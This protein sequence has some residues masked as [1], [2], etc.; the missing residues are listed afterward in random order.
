MTNQPSK[1]GASVPPAPP[2]SQAADASAPLVAAVR[3]HRKA[4]E[5]EDATL[6]EMAALL[7]ELTRKYRRELDQRIEDRRLLTS[8]LCVAELHH[9]Y[10]KREA[11]VVSR[12]I[13][14]LFSLHQ[15]AKHELRVFRRWIN[16]LYPG[17]SRVFDEASRRAASDNSTT[18]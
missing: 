3:R 11:E 7:D 2:S 6:I 12:H 8:S 5:I 1:G 14:G 15:E 4:F 10:L 13:G 16:R 17:W 18:K 9:A